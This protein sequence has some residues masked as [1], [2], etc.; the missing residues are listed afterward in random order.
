MYNTEYDTTVPPLRK[1]RV[2]LSDKSVLIFSCHA[3]TT[4]QALNRMRK[5]YNLTSYEVIE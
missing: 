1:I 2:Y 4:E 3:E 5:I